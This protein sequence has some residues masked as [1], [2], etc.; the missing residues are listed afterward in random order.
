[1]TSVTADLPGTTRDWV[2]GLAQL[3]TPA[4][5]VAVRW[6]DTPGLRATHDHVERVAIELAQH[7]IQ[8]ADALIALRDPQLDWP[9]PSDLPRQPD[10]WV[11]NKADLDQPAPS[12]PSAANHPA[13]APPG[14]DPAN[15][16]PISAL[17]DRGLNDLAQQ[18]AAVLGL[19]PSRLARDVPW[20][21]SPFLRHTLAGGDTDVLSRY[22][23]SI[24]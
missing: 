19:T 9:E 14:A 16:L 17:H 5:H 13:S 4:G 22:I 23:Q 21:F 10:L 12:R 6:L 18:I 20:A 11:L 15:P 2:G 3:T 1:A 8:S 7:M 24:R